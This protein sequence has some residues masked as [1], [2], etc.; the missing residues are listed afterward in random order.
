MKEFVKN[1]IEAASAGPRVFLLAVA[2]L[3][4]A[5]VAP[6]LAAPAEVLH[7]KDGGEWR[8]S[9][10]LGGWEGTGG[11]E[12]LYFWMEFPQGT[13]VLKQTRDGLFWHDSMSKGTVVIASAD[14]GEDANTEPHDIRYV[15]VGT[16]V[17]TGLWNE[18]EPGS[19]LFDPS[20][21]M[22]WTIKATVFKVAPDGEVTGEKWQ[23]YWHLVLRDGEWKETYSFESVK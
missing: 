21:K 4:L 1:P 7:K 23:L 6:S 12:K 5:N 13:S 17:D 11:P 2:L 18:T 22:T 9:W 3:L 19:G 20:E 14:A 15:G 16:M 8:M 10:W